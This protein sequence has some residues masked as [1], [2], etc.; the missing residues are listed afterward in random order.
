MLEGK[1]LEIA[2]TTANAAAQAWYGYDQVRKKFRCRKVVST[3]N[4]KGVI[5]GILIGE[6]FLETFPQTRDPNIQGI[7]ASCFSV[8]PTSLICDAKL[9]L[10]K[11]W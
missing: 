5:S 10:L 9:R 6:D 11:A 8:R 3:N 1:S 2:L 4:W 7:T